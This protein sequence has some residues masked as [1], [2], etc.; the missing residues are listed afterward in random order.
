MTR[1]VEKQTERAVGG[2]GR[3]MVRW[4]RE[5]SILAESET[6]ALAPSSSIVATAAA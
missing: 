1:N 3:E 6:M 2:F 5:T 4:Y